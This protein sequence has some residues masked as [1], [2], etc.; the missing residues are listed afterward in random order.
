M[1]RHQR[2]RKRTTAAMVVAGLNLAVHTQAQEILGGL[3]PLVV[4]GSHFVEPLRNAPVR[5]EVYSAELIA[6]AAARNLAEAIE[7]SPGVRVATDC[8]NCNTQQIQMLGM[9]QQYIGI[10]SDGLPNFTGLAGVYGIEQ[11]P[12]G[13]I[14]GIE[15]VKG[16]GSVLYGPNAVAG[17]INLL[18]RDP[19]E[20]GTILRGQMSNFTEG[21][22]FGRG[23][24]YS[25]MLLH[26]YVNEDAS[27]KATIYYNHD[28][29]QPVDLNG[30]G[31]TDIS[32]RRLHAAGLRLVWQPADDQTLSFD[33]ML[34]DEE[35]RGGDAGAAFE[36]SPDT[37]I[38]AEE[39]FSMRQVA[40]VKW[41]GQLNENWAGTLAYSFSQT[42]RDSYYG[43]LGAFNTPDGYHPN[44]TPF[45]APGSST[46]DTG[47]GETLDQ[48]HF[49][50]ALA[51]HQVHDQNRFTY[52]AQYRYEKIEDTAAS[53]TPLT[54]SFSDVGILAQHRYTPNELWTF[55]YGGRM[56]FHSNLDQPVFS[57]RGSVLYT[58]NQD[59]RIR[60]AV[61][62]GFRAPEVFDEDLHISV[63]GG[64]VQAIRNASDLDEEKSLT[65]SI[66][67]EW[68]IN[69][70]W[71]VETSVFHTSL[72]DTFVVG[73]PD[74]GGAG[75]QLRENGSDSAVYGLEFNL[76]YFADN[77]DVQF[78][79][80]EQRAR[81]DDPFEV[82]EADGGIDA[83]FTDRYTRSPESM[84]QLR[85]T[86]RGSW[87]DT[88][89]NLKLT[90]PMDV[91]R[92]QF[93]SDGSLV[94]QS[95]ERSDWFFNVDIGLRK[96]IQLANDDSLTLSLGIKNLLN[97]FQDDLPSGAYRDPGYI[98]G[99]AF[100]RSI[101]AG[102]SYEF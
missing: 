16:G 3:E 30:D 71:R 19:N 74:S 44:G 45:W 7:A 93:A 59:L 84:G 80:V 102:V 2:T 43:G 90:G 15:V 86:H 36:R 37:N 79:W 50:N 12:A 47:Y 81:H 77:W 92:Q 18:P 83:I 31:F 49:I 56:D 29:L 88:Y 1:K 10:L 75:V 28:Y 6:K 96:E 20:S 53:A 62:T 46:G 78:S 22:S 99:P 61:S 13:L 58:H 65:F 67:P 73:G 52:G 68:Q 82:F 51:I 39:L 94:D 8:G 72:S 23:P 60:G 42:D 32:E 63:V 5:T 89:M 66:S 101:Y 40:T 4:T 57:P 11:I 97:D 17:V 98:Y 34:T 38:I 76:G 24:S 70:Q 69:D 95:L 35:R 9:P 26:D 54:D 64:D 91:P 25:A 41:D 87:C 33:Y 21:N 27:F 55:E 85:F 100:P 14:G 48:L